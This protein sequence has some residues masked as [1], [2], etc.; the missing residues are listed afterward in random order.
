[1]RAS[2]FPITLSYATNDTPL[3]TVAT[4][5]KAAWAQIG[6]NV[7]LQPEPQATLVAQSFGQKNIPLYLLDTASQIFPIGTEFGALYST[8]GFS[9]TT[10]YANPAFDAAFNALELHP[11]PGGDPR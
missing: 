6:V 8:T 7:T 4:V 3:A 10:H 5:L 2:G 9:N 11:Q 1:M